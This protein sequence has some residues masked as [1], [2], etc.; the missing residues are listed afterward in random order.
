MAAPILFRPK[1]TGY[2]AAGI[3]RPP[4]LAERIE[5]EPGDEIGPALD[6]M[7]A[8]TERP[9]QAGAYIKSYRNAQSDAGLDSRR[10]REEPIQPSLCLQRLLGQLCFCGVQRAK[11]R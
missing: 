9:C 7:A 8:H 4:T 1:A 2:P 11:H 5:A 10:P 3:R 6:T